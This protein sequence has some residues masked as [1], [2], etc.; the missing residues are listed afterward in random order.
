MVSENVLD[1]YLALKSIWL[2][3]DLPEDFLVHLN[4]TGDPDTVVPSSFRVGLAAQVSRL[5]PFSTYSIRTHF[6]DLN[7]SRWAIFRLCSLPSYWSS[8]GCHC[9]CKTCSAF[10]SWGCSYTRSC[11]QIE[12]KQIVRLGTQSTTPFPWVRPGTTSPDF[13]KPK[14]MDG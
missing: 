8:T 7:S 10:V 5:A 12:H 3:N 4:L 11:H 14:I 6:L 13:I 9:R 1:I 2:S